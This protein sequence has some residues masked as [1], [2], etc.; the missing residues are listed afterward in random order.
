MDLLE[1]LTRHLVVK[2]GSLE[3]SILAGR[4]IAAKTLVD[5]T[6][7]DIAQQPE[8]QR[9]F[10]V[11]DKSLW[12]VLQITAGAR[13]GVEPVMLA[14]RYREEDDDDHLGF[15]P[16]EEPYVALVIGYA[17]PPRPL[18]PVAPPIPRTH[19][20]ADGTTDPDLLDLPEPTD[21]RRTAWPTT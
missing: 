8:G 19:P 18:V 17:P 15:A 14:L 9:F 12:E 13:K 2:D 1:E 16:Y 7:Q 20:E 11:T 3:G 5:P 21:R 10:D 4:L 6:I